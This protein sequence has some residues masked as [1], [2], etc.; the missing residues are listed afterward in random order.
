[1]EGV[2]ILSIL[3][4]IDRNGDGQIDEAD[5]QLYKA[6]GKELVDATLNFA[7]NM[8]VVGALLLSIVFPI[9]LDQ[10]EPDAKT[11]FT[12][13]TV[14]TLQVMHYMFLQVMAA[15]SFIL[16]YISSRLYAHFA[17]WVIDLNDRLWYI[18]RRAP[19]AMVILDVCQ[20]LVT[21]SAAFSLL[22]GSLVSNS[23]LGLMSLAPLSGALYAW[24]IWEVPQ[25]DAVTKRQHRKVKQM[26]TEIHTAST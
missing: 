18:R 6:C 7:V 24:L 22:F 3:A 26:F 14:S 16:V 1:M 13:T 21:M 8:G 19:S 2:A 17:F 9:C 4:N 23:Y 15:S 10:L 20:I 5:V 25:M 11:P 12:E